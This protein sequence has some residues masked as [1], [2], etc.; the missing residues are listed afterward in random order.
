MPPMVQAVSDNFTRANASPL[1]GNWSIPTGGNGGLQIVSNLVEVVTANGT[2][3][4]EFWN[5]AVLAPG[6]TFPNDQYAEITA[7][8]ILS[9]AGQNNYVG[10]D[11]RVSSGGTGINAYRFQIGFEN[12]V[13]ACYIELRN[14][15]TN[16]TLLGPLAITINPN[17]VYRISSVGT[18]HSIFRNGTFFNSVTDATFASG[19]PGLEE[20][21]SAAGGVGAAKMSLFAA[22]AFQAAAPFFTLVTPSPQVVRITSSTVGCT[23]YYTTDGSTPTEG[24][25]SI[26]NGAT[27]T[28]PTGNTLKAIASLTNFLDSNVTG[29]NQFGGGDEGPAFDFTYRI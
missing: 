12:T 13:A 26:A 11:T 21:S 22:G 15:G 17:D 5:G 27:V 6:G 18:L 19:Q 3:S 20:N 14:N 16:S 25:S 9:S 24:S 1:S 23:I 8:A 28:V 7:A 4:M 29:A 2:L 10:C